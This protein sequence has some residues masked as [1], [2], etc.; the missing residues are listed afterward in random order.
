M[1]MFGAGTS[2]ANLHCAIKPV[3]RYSSMDRTVEDHDA[4]DRLVR[5][6]DE[7]NW[8]MVRPSM[9]KEGARKEVVVRND[10]GSGEG[11]LPSSVTIGTVVEF[12]LGCVDSDEWDGRTPVIV[13]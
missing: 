13:N 10:E 9:L 5:G 11:W 12:L 2:F 7:V 6:Q 4:V 1:S 8:V 3:M